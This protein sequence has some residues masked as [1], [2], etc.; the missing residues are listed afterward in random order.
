[1]TWEELKE[2]AKELGYTYIKER[3]VKR[4]YKNFEDCKINFKKQSGDVVIDYEFPKTAYYRILYRHISYDEMY[5]MMEALG[6]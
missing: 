1:M 6:D 4:L 3:G 5:E 2:R